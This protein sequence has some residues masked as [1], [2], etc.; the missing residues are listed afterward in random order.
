MKDGASTLA[1]GNQ[2]LADGM[3]EFKE[4]GIDKIVEI[5]NGDINTVKE[6]INTMTELGKS[7]KSF[8][9]IKDGMNGSTKFIIETEGI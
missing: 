2:E 9:G 5:F 8:A 6:R 4:N 3:K 7:Y 1:D